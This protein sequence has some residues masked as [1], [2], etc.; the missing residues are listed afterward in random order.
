[1]LKW[2]GGLVD[3]NEKAL[4][5]IEPLVEEING[6]EPDFEKLSNEE[7]RAKTAEFKARIEKERQERGYYAL[8]DEARAHQAEGRGDEAK[9]ALKELR[10]LGGKIK[11]EHQ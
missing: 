2:L 1:M 4:R 10:T 5:R 11:S 7:L 9:A 6:L 3:S 8:V